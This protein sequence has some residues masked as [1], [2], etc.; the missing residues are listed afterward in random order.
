MQAKNSV[1]EE[2]IKIA[3]KQTQMLCEN[4]VKQANDVVDNARIKKIVDAIFDEKESPLVKKDIVAYDVDEL[5]QQDLFDVIDNV[6]SNPQ[7][8]KS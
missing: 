3:E 1:T 8:Q 5:E 7:K 6:I 2:S 4:I